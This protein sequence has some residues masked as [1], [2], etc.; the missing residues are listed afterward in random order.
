MTVAV[1][2]RAGAARVGAQSETKAR[3]ANIRAKG[4]DWVI[5]FVLR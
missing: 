5:M 4:L 3:A 1:C 2:A